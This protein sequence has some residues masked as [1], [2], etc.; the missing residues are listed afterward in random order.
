M[1]ATQLELDE[2][3]EVRVSWARVQRENKPELLSDDNAD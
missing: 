3:V 1:K 2:V